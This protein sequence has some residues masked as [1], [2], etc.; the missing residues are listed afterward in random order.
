MDKFVGQGLYSES[1]K[2]Q[3][4]DSIQRSRIEE[5]HHAC[6]CGTM[7]TGMKGGGAKVGV[8]CSIGLDVY[9]KAGVGTDCV[10]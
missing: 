6:G 10:A 4:F 5:A 9:E 7:P 1:K 3:K 8:A 2:A